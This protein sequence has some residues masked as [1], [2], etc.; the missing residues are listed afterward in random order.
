MGRAISLERAEQLGRSHAHSH[1]P[2]SSKKIAQC[3]LV[4]WFE[5]NLSSDS[6]HDSCLGDPLILP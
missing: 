4:Q 2:P 6:N 3:R 1:R 5:W